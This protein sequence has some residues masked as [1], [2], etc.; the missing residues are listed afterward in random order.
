[1]PI[2]TSTY[3]HDVVQV[4]KLGS[5]YQ[6]KYLQSVKMPGWEPLEPIQA[7]NVNNYKLS[8]NRSRALTKCREIALS[9]DWQYFITLT[10]DPK[11]YDRFDLP[12]FHHDL[13]L[14]FKRINRYRN[15]PIKYLLV[16]EKH[17]N[18]AWHLHG[19]VNGLSDLDI[20]KN[21]NGFFQFDA[22]SSQFGYNS[23]SV[24]NS[25]VAVSLYVSKHISKQI[26]NGVTQIGS[27]LYY[28]S[29][30]LKRGEIV[31]LYNAA[32]MPLNFKFQYESE[33]HAFKSSFFEDDTF[34]KSLNLI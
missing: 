34:L 26:Q 16:P 30:G 14:F 2:K 28:C 8:N 12:K 32:S 3:E 20:S 4:I 13:S 21:S 25:N 15:Q 31:A 18:G 7:K 29:R 11:K 19:L 1:M 22:Y 10:L 9:N 6:V 33:D 17:K 27:H 24:I 5:H 23:L